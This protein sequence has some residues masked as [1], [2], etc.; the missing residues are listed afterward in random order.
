M[1]ACLIFSPKLRR[2]TGSLGTGGRQG[3]GRLIEM[4]QSGAKGLSFWSQLHGPG[5]SPGPGE[6]LH[7]TAAL[8]LLGRLAGGFLYTFLMQL[9]VIFDADSRG[10]KRESSE[11]PSGTSLVVQR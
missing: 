1:F 7:F 8:S 11:V 10:R 6:E 2:H 4:V 3:S 5:I 9:L